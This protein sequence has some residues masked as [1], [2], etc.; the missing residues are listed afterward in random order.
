MA[1]IESYKKSIIKEQ[2]KNENLT[3][4]IN[5]R[6]SEH[7]NLD[8]SLKLNK[9]RKDVLQQE[10]SAFDRAL[11]E[12][13]S[14]LN[15]VNS[16][17]AQNTYSL[18]QHQREV[19]NL[20]Q[21]KVKLEDEIFKK[22]QDKLTA[23]KAAQ[24]TDKLR[25]EQTEKL[26]DMERNLVKMENDVAKAK[27]DALQTK[28]INEAYERE[29]KMLQNEI[30]D[31]NKIISKSESEIKQRVLIIEHKQGQIDLYN[32]KIDALIEKAGV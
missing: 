7:K 26:R 11:K 20:N 8:K 10:F 3:L 1:E 31:K 5:T 32:K 2:E 4:M 12:T 14:Q 25:K 22:L 16:E 23:D 6:K 28:T 15:S 18:N 21:E 30:E 29:V 17:K 13:V 19:E 9:E 24:Y 27:L